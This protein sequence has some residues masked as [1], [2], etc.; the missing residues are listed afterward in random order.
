LKDLNT[1]DEGRQGQAKRERC[2]WKVWSKGLQAEA[3]RRGALDPPPL[4]ASGIQGPTKGG[5]EGRDYQKNRKK[6]VFG[7]KM[8]KR[9]LIWKRE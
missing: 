1:P 5:K 4:E 6:N 9:E 7:T 3:S 2:L 8:E